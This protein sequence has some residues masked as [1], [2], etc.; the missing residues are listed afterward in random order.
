MK[1]AQVF[2]HYQKT[3]E[4]KPAPELPLPKC[5]TGLEWEFEM[6]PILRQALGARDNKYLAVHEDGSLRDN[7]V[8]V[9]TVGDGLWGVDLLAAI[10]YLNKKIAEVSIV[11]APPVCN[12]RT[13]FHVHIDVRDMEAAQ[14]HNMLLLYALVEIPI[15]NFVGNDRYNSNF[16]VPW[17]RAESQFN[18]LK[19]LRDDMSTGEADK[20]RTLQRYSAL[21]CQAIAKYG[22]VEF[23]HMQNDISELKTKQIEF[24]KIAQKLKKQGIYLYEKGLHGKALFSYFKALTPR[25]LLQATELTMLPTNGWDYPEALMQAAGMVDFQLPKLTDFYDK[26][27]APFVGKH[28]NFK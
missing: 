1:P 10:D 21:N 14:I 11:R 3:L 12:Y 6:G 4:L 24:I 16:C 9:V 8:E 17:G 26:M 18:V 25:E 23:R 15:F 22:T 7:G 13:A 27:F 20:L 5:S 19:S 2:N 28:P